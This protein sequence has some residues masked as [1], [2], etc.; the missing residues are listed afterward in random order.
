MT[1]FSNH[2]EYEAW[3]ARWCRKCTHDEVGTAP[4]GT[5]CP[6]LGV[7]LL[8][9]TVPLQWTPGVDDRYHCSEFGAPG[10]HPPLALSQNGTVVHR[11]GCPLA[12]GG[13]PWFWS[14]GRSTDACRTL[15]DLAGWTACAHCGPFA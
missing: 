10:E 5:Y 2:T 6:I 3:S 7:A 15:T 9:N 8:D 1:A 11:V 12:F 14:H 13:K 4:A